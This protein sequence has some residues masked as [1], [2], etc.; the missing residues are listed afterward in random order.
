MTLG[1]EALAAPRALRDVQVVRARWDHPG[2]RVL[3]L[4]RLV[5]FTAAGDEY[6]YRL[7]QRGIDRAKETL[8]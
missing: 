2:Y 7:N 3:R 6:D 1:F 4:H 5:T 8:R